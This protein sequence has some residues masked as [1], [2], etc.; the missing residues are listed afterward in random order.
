VG[1]ILIEPLV[2]NPVTNVHK[3]FELVAK[4]TVKRVDTFPSKAALINYF[5]KHPVYKAWAPEPVRVFAEHATLTLPDGSITLKTSKYVEA[6]LASNRSSYQ[7]VWYSLR[8]L[9]DT[10]PVVFIY[11]SKSLLLPAY[12]RALTSKQPSNASTLTVEGGHLLV[13]ENPQALAGCIHKALENLC[14]FCIPAVKK[15]T[16]NTK[17]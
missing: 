4:A 3:P 14:T 6:E 1:L 16:S 17:L 12:S 9:S 8:S 7:S 13:Q 11:G 10:V 15:R 5:S 2:A